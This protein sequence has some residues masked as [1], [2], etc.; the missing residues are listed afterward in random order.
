[1][2]WFS[3]FDRM[4]FRTRKSQKPIDRERER[5][6]EMR[7]K[8]RG[9]TV[10]LEGDEHRPRVQICAAWIQST[11]TRDEKVTTG[12]SSV[13]SRPRPTRETHKRVRYRSLSIENYRKPRE[14]ISMRVPLYHI[15]ST[16]KVI[17]KNNNDNTTNNNN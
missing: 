4:G 15:R 1:M 13:D 11:R 16:T 7:K 6:R 2:C 3:L 5:K 9:G 10:R 12:A 17:V 14:K 8:K